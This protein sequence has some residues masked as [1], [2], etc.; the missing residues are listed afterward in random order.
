MFYETPFLLSVFQFPFKKF[1][2]MIFRPMITTFNRIKDRMD[3][4]LNMI[5]YGVPTPSRLL[6]KKSAPKRG[7]CSVCFYDESW[8]PR[9][10]S[11]NTHQC[12]IN[13]IAPKVVFKVYN[14]QDMTPESFL[15]KFEELS[16]FETVYVYICLHGVLE[17]GDY[18]LRLNEK[19]SISNTLL[20]KV[21][22]STTTYKVFLETCH[23][24][25]FFDTGVLNGA[26][27]YNIS[28]F[29]CSSTDNKAIVD[30]KGGSSYGRM[31][32]SIR[33]CRTNPYVTPYNVHYIN[34]KYV[35]QNYSYE[36]YIKK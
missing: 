8:T 36:S 34:S 10:K 23:S 3:P 13:Q 24:E 5:L 6:D 21:L 20:S 7:T 22:V 1:G 18:K 27:E 19:Y 17:N 26:K 15:T 4:S 28:I 14:T 31:T 11:V 16:F 32:E 2:T 9:N 29:N 25:A 30:I 35:K 33:I 12:W